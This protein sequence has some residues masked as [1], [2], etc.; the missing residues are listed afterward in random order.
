MK[1]R[2]A[3]DFKV[4]VSRRPRLGLWGAILLLGLPG[5]F[6]AVAG[7]AET[8]V[9]RVNSIAELRQAIG[10]GTGRVCAYSLEGTVL[11]ANRVGSTV[12]FQDASGTAALNVHWEGVPL[13]AGQ[14][15]RLAATNTVS[16]TDTGLSL[17]ASPLVDVDGRHPA[18]EKPGTIFLNAGR[19]PL[20]IDWFNWASSA[21]LDL[22]YSGPGL[23]K[24]PVPPAA[25]WLTPGP[26]AGNANAGLHGL[27]FRCYA[28]SWDRMPNFDRLAPLKTGPISHLDV[29]VRS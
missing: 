16:R 3:E 7:A 24:Q 9:P 10:P 28:G 14:H 13:Q 15:I 19:H 27:Q 12:L 11:A 17:G 1:Y 6:H 21:Q 2:L 23:E 29:S 8:G 5:F 25:Y 26:E 22:A 4:N 20:R 18:L